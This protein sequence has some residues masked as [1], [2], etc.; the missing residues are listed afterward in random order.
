VWLADFGLTRVDILSS[1]TAASLIVETSAYVAPEQWERTQIDQ[2]ADV[3]AL[4]VILFEALTATLPFELGPSFLHDHREP[5][6]PSSIRGSVP[7]QIDDLIALALARDPAQ[8]L[9]SAKAFA[10]A[11]RG[12][13]IRSA[14]ARTACQACGTALV[15]GQRLCPAC[16]SLAVRFTHTAVDPEDRAML[17]LTKAR[18]TTEF[19]TRLHEFLTA[20][21]REVDE[22]D[23]L[24]G[25]PQLYSQAERSRL[26]QLPC[27]VVSHIDVSTAESLQSELAKR[28]IETDVWSKARQRGRLRRVERG[29]AIGGAAVTFAAIVATAVLWTAQPIGFVILAGLG[30][31]FTMITMAIVRTSF[32][33]RENQL[34]TAAPLIALRPQSA[35]L[36]AS[37]PL[38]AK[39]AAALGR[40]ATA[41]DVRKLVG[42]LALWVQRLVDRKLEFSGQ[43]AEISMLTEPVEPLIDFLVQQI[44][45]LQ[46]I[47]RE[48][49]SL[50]EGKLTRNLAAARARS[51]RVESDRTLNDLDRLRELEEQRARA[52]HRLLDTG[53]LLRRNIELGLSVV[54]ETEEHERHVKVALARLGGGEA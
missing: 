14:E 7:Q 45:G 43:A 37:D 20:I 51:D 15:V 26:R 48:L 30:A 22:L 10:A 2:R 40:T 19:S 21:G 12:E 5:I 31:L 8:R 23:F 38:V 24:I 46:T 6:R 18:E 25:S 50:D 4:G 35:A 41:D 1:R 36:P 17:V 9:P 33:V 53:E 16:G 29:I 42:E 49:T 54:D 32:S 39:L 27:P 34:A 13:S 3:Y 28:G 11:L 47:D 52:F 44:D